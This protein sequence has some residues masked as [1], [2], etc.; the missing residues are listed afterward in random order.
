MIAMEKNIAEKEIRGPWYRVW[1]QFLRE[2][3]PKMMTYKQRPEE[4]NE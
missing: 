2:W 1:M 3:L 4:V